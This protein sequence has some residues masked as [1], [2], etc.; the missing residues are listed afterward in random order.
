LLTTRVYKSYLNY[1]LNP[2]AL[3]AVSNGMRAVKLSTNK[4]LTQIDLY[5]D[6]GCSAVTVGCAILF[7][8]LT[9]VSLTEL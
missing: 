3:V 5:N 6:R 1:L 4:I 7:Q 2:N 8:R 9:T